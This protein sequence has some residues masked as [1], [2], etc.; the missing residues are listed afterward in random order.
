MSVAF[1]APSQSSARTLAQAISKSASGNW[2]ESWLM[3]WYWSTASGMWPVSTSSRPI[4]RWA[5]ST[6]RSSRS[7]VG[8]LAVTSEKRAIAPA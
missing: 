1:R 6:M 8:L 7:S 2:G 5:S 4:A 3:P